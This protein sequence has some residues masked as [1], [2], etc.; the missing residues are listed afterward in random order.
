LPPKSRRRFDLGIR[1]DCPH[2]VTFAN[3][4]AAIGAVGLNSLQEPVG[5]AFAAGST[6][7]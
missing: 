1:F 7:I 6:R 3:P 2:V 4:G 5:V